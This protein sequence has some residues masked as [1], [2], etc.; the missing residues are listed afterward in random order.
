MIFMGIC[1]THVKCIPMQDDLLIETNRKTFCACRVSQFLPLFITV[2]VCYCIL[3]DAFLSLLMYFI[4]LCFK[5]SEEIL[6][7][8]LS[9]GLKCTQI[10]TDKIIAPEFL[11]CIH[12][13]NTLWGSS[14]K[15][16]VFNANIITFNNRQTQEFFIRHFIAP[17][18]KKEH[19]SSLP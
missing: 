16:Y 9:S 12:T 1:E 7:L 13:V 14:D 8:L 19:L 15:Q 5:G 6:L 18:F 10:S 11:L 4:S 17:P 3:C 2:L